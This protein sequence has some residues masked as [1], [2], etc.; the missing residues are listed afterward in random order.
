MRVAIVEPGIINTQMAT[1]ISVARDTSHY[2]NRDRM[3]AL[4]RSALTNPTPPSLVA[5]K[6]LEIAFSGTWQLRHPVGPDAAPFIA[7]RQAM[8]DEEWV[9]WGALDDEAWYARVKADFVID[10]RPEG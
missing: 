10:G 8:S 3:A 6:V 7:W 9:N 2:P 1:R 5:A 4:F